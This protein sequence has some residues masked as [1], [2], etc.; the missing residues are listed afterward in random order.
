LIKKKKYRTR[1]RSIPGRRV[2][3]I[4]MW[5]HGLRGGKKR[6]TLGSS[7]IL[8]LREQRTDIRVTK[9]SG[10]KDSNRHIRLLI[11]ENKK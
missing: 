5:L 7:M 8:L 6:F 9:G 1:E 4:N 2:L 3:I 10:M 11:A